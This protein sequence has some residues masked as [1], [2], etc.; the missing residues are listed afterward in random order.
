MFSPLVPLTIAALLMGQQ[1]ISAP[2]SET[3]DVGAERS[4]ARATTESTLDP[5]LVAR[6]EA[7]LDE[8]FGGSAM[9]GVTVGLWIPGQGE[10]VAT[11]GVSNTS[12][13]QPMDRANQS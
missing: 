9:P 10:W 12:T 2:V 7:V 13:N 3:H 6:L 4:A 5:A 8:G 11:R 1:S